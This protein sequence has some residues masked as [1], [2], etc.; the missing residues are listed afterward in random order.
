MFG[1]LW[2]SFLCICV[3]VFFVYGVVI[4][5]MFILVFVSGVS[6]CVLSLVSWVLS[7]CF[8]VLNCG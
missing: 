7:V 5:L 1:S 6:C 8:I 3:S 4:G 2:L